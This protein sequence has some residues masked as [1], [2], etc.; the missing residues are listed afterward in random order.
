MTVRW[1]LPKYTTLRLAGRLG[2]IYPWAAQGPSRVPREYF[3]LRAVP[4]AA[5]TGGRAGS[6]GRLFRGK[7]KTIGVLLFSKHTR[8]VI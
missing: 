5:R 2:P 4:L 6:R 3:V 1:G 7:R 8:C